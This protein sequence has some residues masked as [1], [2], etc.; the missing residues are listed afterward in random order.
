MATTVYGNKKLDSAVPFPC[1]STETGQDTLEAVQGAS[2]VENTPLKSAR[3]ILSTI[4][5]EHADYWDHILSNEAKEKISE[6]TSLRSEQLG[7]CT[8]K[9]VKRRTPAVNNLECVGC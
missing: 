6:K 7:Y 4:V 8:Q 3:T 1:F 2:T 9:S 5:N